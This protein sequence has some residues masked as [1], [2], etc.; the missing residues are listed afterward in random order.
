MSGS[1]W[2]PE[3]KTQVV[4]EV[5]EK[6]RT[7][8]EVAESYDLVAQTVGEWVKKHRK[9]H[10]EPGT[11]DLTGD[12]A[13]ELERLKKELREA[14][15]ENEFLKK[16]QPT[17]RRSH[18]RRPLHLHRHPGRRLPHRA[19]VPLPARVPVRVLRLAEPAGIGGRIAAP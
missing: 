10:L 13:K 15:M 3:F 4:L 19:H 7:I 2:S 11:E 16:R 1:K 5:V 12:E 9:E 17:S 6:H 18:D 14:R 8:K